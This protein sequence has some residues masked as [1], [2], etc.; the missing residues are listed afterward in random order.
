MLYYSCRQPLGCIVMKFRLTLVSAS[1][2]KH[3]LIL[4]NIHVMGKGSH[5][6]YALWQIVLLI[7]SRFIIL[8]SGK[9]QKK[10]CRKL[11]KALI[12]FERV[13]SFIIFTPKTY[14]WFLKSRFHMLL[15]KTEIPCGKSRFSKCN[16]THI[17]VWH[18][19]KC[20]Y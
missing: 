9:E 12:G 19:L 3:A 13:G 2:S 6:S 1:P 11:V 7:P 15:P 14:D 4:V 20:I 8:I 16:Y 5:V 10:V 18:Y 17:C